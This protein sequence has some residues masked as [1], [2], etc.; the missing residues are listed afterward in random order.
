MHDVNGKT[1][2]VNDMIVT[3]S[4]GIMKITAVVDEDNS[5]GHG[6]LVAV[7]D[8][9][10]IHRG[11]LRL[12]VSG[13]VKIPDMKELARQALDCQDACNLSGVAHTFSQVI[14]ELRFL[15]QAQA[16]EGIIERFS[17]DILNQHPICV[18]FASKIVS[19]TSYEET[20]H[21]PGSFCHAYDWAKDMVG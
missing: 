12:H 21:H 18:L 8:T 20:G 17:T 4:F 7:S 14:S 16:K 9:E 13:A 5:E 15:L 1:L 11:Y 19:L 6:A 3:P 10:N 2:H